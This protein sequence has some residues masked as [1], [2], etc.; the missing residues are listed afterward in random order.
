MSDC[1]ELNLRRL[2]GFVIEKRFA[3]EFAERFNILPLPS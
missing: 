2:D 3:S 1:A